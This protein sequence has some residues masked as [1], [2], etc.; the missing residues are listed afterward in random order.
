LNRYG[1]LKF[2]TLYS[3]CFARHEQA[4][5]CLSTAQ[6]PLG[7]GTFALA[8]QSSAAEGLNGRAAMAQG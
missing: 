3:I 6:R 4:E 8:A 5:R 1:G 7:T 2:S